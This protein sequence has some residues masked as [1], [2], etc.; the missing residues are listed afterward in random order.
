MMDC[1]LSGSL[2]VVYSLFCYAM[3]VFFR[4]N[5]LSLSLSIA[6]CIAVAWNAA[7]WRAGAAECRDTF[8]RFDNLASTSAGRT[9]PAT[10]VSTLD[11]CRARCLRDDDC[12]GFNWM[13]D[14]RN[15]TD[16]C[17]LYDG[18]VG[19]TSEVTLFDLY[20]RE[21][22]QPNMFIT[23]GPGMP[24]THT[25]T[26]THTRTHPFNSPFSGTTQ[27]SRYQKGKT[28]LDV[29]EARDSE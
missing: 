10:G 29:T 13:R 9:P 4:A 3:C 1:V 24:L 14:G 6:L 11:E 21:R 20:A 15:D 5:K 23:F 26:H 28:N 7:V 27:V 22:C 8:V 16:K 18:L 2:L 12:A 19:D 17:L 25:H